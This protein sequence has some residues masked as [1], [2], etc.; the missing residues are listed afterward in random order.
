MGPSESFWGDRQLRP[1]ELGVS[2][3]VGQLRNDPLITGPPAPGPLNRVVV[4]VWGL[5]VDGQWAVTD[6]FGVAGEFFIGQGLGNYNG[7]IFQVFNSTTFGGIRARGGWGEAYCYLTDRL[8]LHCG[9]GIDA[10]I[11]RDLAATQV[12][13]NQTYY[14]TLLWDV[15]SAFQ[16]GFDVE[17]RETDYIAFPDAEGVLFVTQM[18]WRF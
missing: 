7:G 3:V 16:V 6:W 18:M 15:S 4:N 17:Y 12:A 11:R 13:R 9:Y 10:P 14:A 8:H 5:C 1:L 2:G